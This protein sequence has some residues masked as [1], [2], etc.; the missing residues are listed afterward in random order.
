M[1]VFPGEKTQLHIF[2]PRYRQLVADARTHNFTF[3]IPLVKNN[4]MW[5]YGTEVKINHVIRHYDTG[6]CDIE[7]EGVRVFHV[8]TLQN[9]LPDKL[10]AGGRVGFLQA[11]GHTRDA[12]TYELFV[13]YMRLKD[14]SYSESRAASYYHM[15]SEAVTDVRQRMELLVID[16]EDGLRSEL[17]KL[18]LLLIGSAEAEKNTGQNF[19]YN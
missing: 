12:S 17:R 8:Q 14:E 2:E 6:E 7:I 3:G 13:R 10:Y 9:P 19:I 1:V 5:E 16:S 15:I 11:V 18:L 4:R